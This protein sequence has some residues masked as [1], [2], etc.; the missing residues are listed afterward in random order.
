VPEPMLRFL[1]CLLC[2]LVLR[3]H[4]I[5]EIPIT[6]E[7][8]G[9]TAVCTAHV[10]AA[11]MLPEFR[12]D[13]DE[14]PKDLVW[15]RELGPEG[16]R[17]IEEATRIFW[18]DSLK[19]EADGKEL[20]WTLEIPEIHEPSPAFMTVGEPEEL[21]MLDAVIRAQLPPGTRKLEATWKEPFGVVLVA[22]VRKDAEAE[23]KPIVSGERMTLAERDETD[24]APVL[25]RSATGSSWASITSFHWGSITSF[26][27]SGS[28]S[29]PPNGGRCSSRRSP[30]PSRTRSPWAWHPWAGWMSL[31]RGHPS[32]SKCLSPP[33]SLGSALR[34]CW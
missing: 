23:V 22:T 32:G 17:K 34:T 25:A 33:A 29:L 13:E 8:A 15:L 7:I 28:S 4:Q 1:F 24:L 10:D 18:K 16:W 21:P 31:P 2:P 9:D 14:E 6:L 20:E 19:L 27:S 30:L 5:A 3:A 26:S 12:G 11:Y